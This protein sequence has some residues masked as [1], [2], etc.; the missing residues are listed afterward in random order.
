VTEAL[1]A[2][3]HR[4]MDAVESVL[5]EW[6]ARGYIMDSSTPWDYEEH[7]LPRSAWFKRA[8]AEFHDLRGFPNNPQTFWTNLKRTLTTRDG[9][10]LL[11]AANEGRRVVRPLRVQRRGAT[12][13]MDGASYNDRWYTLP[14]LEDVRAFW[15]AEKCSTETWS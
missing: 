15:V 1:T 11:R 9:Q 2:Q 6:L 8:Q 10:C 12:E 3:K 14:S 4:S 7:T 5:H 13:M